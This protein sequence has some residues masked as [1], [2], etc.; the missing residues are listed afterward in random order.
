MTPPRQSLL[1]VLAGAALNT[2]KEFSKL[3]GVS[4]STVSRALSSQNLKRPSARAR[5]ERIRALAAE[6]GYAPNGLARS[7]KTN[8]RQ[9]VGLMLPDI[10]NDYYAAAATLVQETL[11]GEGYRVLLCVTNDDP[12]T[13]AAQRRMLYEE[14]V[15]GIVVVPGPRPARSVAHDSAGAARPAIPV[16]E[17]VRQSAPQTA[18]AVL[19]D[20]VDAAWQGTQHLIALGHRR[21][22]ILTGPPSLSTSRQRLAGY[23]RALDEAGIAADDALISSGPYRRDVARAATLRLLDRPEWPSALIATS[24]ELVVGVLQALAQRDVRVPHDL[25]LV[26]FG[27]PDWFGLLKPALT[28]VALPIEEMAMVAVHLLLKR[29]RQAQTPV[30]ATATPP[31]ISR[32]QAQLIVRESTAVAT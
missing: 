18:D 17:L 21:I 28:T 8:Q 25:S 2:L 27:N 20:D 7:L 3:L 11:A 32:Y 22:A 13:E 10:L 31:V 19:I 16:I 12:A 1:C 9:I 30:S 14:R 26:G 5:A 4:P 15:A 24:N 23:C 6:M 29:I